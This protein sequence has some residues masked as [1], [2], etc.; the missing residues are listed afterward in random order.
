[1]SPFD[2][3]MFDLLT[4]YNSTCDMSDILSFE[5]QLTQPPQDEAAPIEFGVGPLTES[6]QELTLP[7][8]MFDL[9]TGGTWQ[10]LPDIESSIDPAL[11]TVP[12]TSLDDPAFST[13]FADEELTVPSEPAEYT[14]DYPPL[15]PSF[16]KDETIFS[17]QTLDYASAPFSPDDPLTEPTASPAND[18]PAVPLN[19]KPTNS[20]APPA[21]KKGKKT[22]YQPL[23]NTVGNC[24]CGLCHGAPVSLN[25]LDAE[26]INELNNPRC[27]PQARS[28]KGRSPKTIVKGKGKVTQCKARPPTPESDA[29]SSFSSFSGFSSSSSSSS[30]ARSSK[31]SSIH[32]SVKGKGKRKG[33]VTM[34]RKARSPTPEWESESKPEEDEDEE[35]VEEYKP[36]QSRSSLR[37]TAS[38]RVGKAKAKATR[39]KT[40]RKKRVVRAAAVHGMRKFLRDLEIDMNGW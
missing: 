31:G 8:E 39:L 18:K 36:P 28:S 29:E 4:E 33:K 14:L 17:P 19:T 7:M 21:P 15:P 32:K 16:T 37:K 10:R 2:E 20:A 38:G 11:L 13:A 6:S 12:D 40:R 34:K 26:T 25:A 22:Y 3:S 24:P 1:M 35:E 23:L 9:C 30:E 27:K 5:E